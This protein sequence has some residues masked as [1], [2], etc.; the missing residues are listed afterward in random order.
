LIRLADRFGGAVG[1]LLGVVLLTPVFC[2]VIV[3]GGLW[4]RLRGRDPLHR[5]LRPPDLSYWIQR[6]T[7]PAPHQYDRQFLIEDKA[8]RA[9]RRPLQEPGQGGG[10]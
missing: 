8:A 4:L 3:P 5:R 9:E 1:R 7:Q 10:A 2:L 6:R